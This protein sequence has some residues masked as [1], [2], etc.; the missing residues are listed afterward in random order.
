MS[1]M[2]DDDVRELLRTRAQPFALRKNSTGFTEWCRCYGIH[3]AHASDFMQGRRKHPPADVL[4]ALHL[5]RCYTK[6]DPSKKRT[7]P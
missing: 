2:S 1:M 5:Y 7:K 3:K 6:R 4:N